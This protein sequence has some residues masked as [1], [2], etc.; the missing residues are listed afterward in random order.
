MSRSPL[1]RF[2]DGFSNAVRFDRRVCSQ[3]GGCIA[4]YLY[5]ISIACPFLLMRFLLSDLFFRFIFI[6]IIIIHYLCG[7]CERSGHCALEAHEYRVVD[8]RSR[9][10]YE[11]CSNIVAVEN[12]PVLWLGVSR[13]SALTSVWCVIIMRYILWCRCRWYYIVIRLDP[14]RRSI[15]SP[16][17][18][19]LQRLSLFFDLWFSSIEHQ[20]EWMHEW[21]GRCV[22]LC[23]SVRYWCR[24]SN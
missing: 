2:V 12:I 16:P 13:I 15:F 17:S 14:P 21:T 20:C 1:W 22:C 10:R 24:F 5:Q 11:L 4:V 7:D 9:R 6:V 19:W 18:C 3:H 23:L 8:I